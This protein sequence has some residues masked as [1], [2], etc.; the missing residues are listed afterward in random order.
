MT[1]AGQSPFI[2]LARHGETAWSISGQHTGLTDIP[3]TQR[4]E[5]NAR[6]LALRLQGIIFWRVFTSPLQRARQTCALAGFAPVAQIEPDLVEWN[7]GDYEGKTSAQ[8]QKIRPGWEIFNDGCPDGESPADIGIRADRVIAKLR[9]AGGNVLI[10]SHGH[11]LRVLTARW[12]SL[13]PAAGKLFL[14]DTAALSIVGY[15][16]AATDSVI[17]LWNDCR[18]T[19]D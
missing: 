6:Q 7:Y 2:Y 8:I 4:G 13:A 18:H 19:C 12:L 9:S 15:E 1:T 5:R 11:F 16:H 17:R 14:L 10:F 3:L